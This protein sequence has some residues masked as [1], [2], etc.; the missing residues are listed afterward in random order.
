MV[1]RI[2]FRTKLLASHAAVALAVGAV[3][4]LV[5]ERVVSDRMESQ[6]DRRLEAQAQAVSSWLQRAGHPDRLAGRLAGVVGAR[7][8]FV[9]SLGRSV[10]ESRKD[11]D[12]EKAVPADKLPAEIKSARQGTVGRATRFSEPDQ[13]R[14]RYVAVPASG[15]AV[16]RLGVPIGEIEDI[17]S[18]IR[19]QLALGAIVPL[20]VALGLAAFVAV[21]L[22][23]RLHEATE[24]A[25]R[26]GAGDY[27]VSAARASSDEV[28]VL[29][30]TLVA[31]A[32]ELEAT[33]ARRREFLANVAHEIRTPVTSIRGYAETLESSELDANTRR[34]FVHTIHRNSVRIARLVEDL[35]ELEALQAGKGPPMDAES[36]EI[37]QIA[38]NVARTVQG[39]VADRSPAIDLDIADD[40]TATGDADAIERVLLNLVDNA[41]RHGGNHVRVGAR[42]KAERVIITVRDD[43]PG[44]P[45]EQRGRIFERFH[46]VDTAANPDQAGSGLGLAISRDLAQAMGGSLALTHTDAAGASFTFELPC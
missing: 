36:I 17:K 29:T 10:G 41:I 37:A 38:K 6:V 14:V 44:I 40:L 30:R 42:R 45:D 32:A 39:R 28:G 2:S 33:E 8:T 11:V 12:V 19:R 35:L 26:I 46:R 23:R 13:A 25:R 22:T 9:D 7:V 24:I 21:S 3:S 43:G 18:E 4:L 1:V 5:I 20:V 16:V 31:G 15:G 27:D 34:E